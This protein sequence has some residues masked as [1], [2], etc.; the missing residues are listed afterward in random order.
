MMAGI[1]KGL[2]DR[3]KNDVLRDFFIFLSI[4]RFSASYD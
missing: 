4:T 3:D 1:S 2:C